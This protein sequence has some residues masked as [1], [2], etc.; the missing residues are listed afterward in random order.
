[1][2][3]D[4]YVLGVDVGGTFTDLA[5]I[6]LADGRAFYHKISSTPADPSVAVG[7]GI[8]TLLAHANVK[9]PQ[10]QY[11]G[12][13]TTVAT[14]AVI[15]GRTA[16]TGL[17]TTEGF[18]DILE[19]RRQ[20][21]PHNY[22]IRLDKPKPPVA[23]HLRREMRERV[24]LSGDPAVA[25][26]PAA[27]DPILADFKREGVEAIAICFLHSY[28]RPAHEALIAQ[29]VRERFPEAFTCASHEVLAEFREYE[30]V[31]TTAL[32][33]ALG[34][35]MSRYLI[36]LEKRA[37]AM[38]L[39][40]PKI[41]QSNGGVASA[42][43]AGNQAV[44]TLVSGPAA[45]VTG[46][47][48]LAVAAEIPDIITFDVG[49][50]STDVCLVEKGQPLI[51]RQRNFHGFPVRFPM[52]DVHSVGAGGG[53]IAWVDAG[54]F[55]H[56]GPQSAGADPGPACYDRGGGLPT[57]TD[58][59]VVLGR[60]PPD[61]LLGG[62]MPIRA[63][64][65]RRAIEERIAVPMGLGLEAAAQ[66]I[67]TILN[68]N[69]MQAI[70]VISVEKGFDPR[71]FTLVAF[72]GGG[73]LLASV[74]AREL[75][76]ATVMVP[77]HP[78]LLCAHGLLVADVRSDFSLSRLA[79][80]MQAGTPAINAG[81]ADLQRSVD[82]WFD[83]E[84]IDPAERGVERALDLRFAGQSHELTV[85]VQRAE[86]RDQDLPALIARFREE[87][88][89]VYGYAPDGALQIVTYRITARTPV[90]GPR[91]ATGIALRA[92]SSP[93]RTGSRPVHFPEAG[94]FVDCPIYDRAR[95]AAAARID[96][97]AILEQMDTT[98][99]VLPGQIARVQADGNVLLTFG[100]T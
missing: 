65:A 50:T 7:E 38:G 5:L 23:R 14:N 20:R 52:V 13:G 15:M 85:P 3:T 11:F 27:L 57:V 82:E 77:P 4:R 99:V 17:I 89:R 95:L 79:N 70:R 93:A 100:S 98:T 64:L 24:Y 47:A 61:A 74:L 40:A 60:L 83:R 58:A 59:N 72:G 1:V 16:R 96:G 10:V 84:G 45:G 92:A 35:V 18:R 81:F 2:N 44:R 49:G 91:S 62:R 88:V 28:V 22:D 51:A 33:A 42:R 94:G 53:S 37:G 66:G 97:P 6:R 73:P 21:Q 75:G 25:P 30:R 76:M 43:E 8:E 78:G 41:L 54:G 55:L 31:S 46:A 12:H 87:H 9:P 86:F 34:P 32:N 26:D 68:E 90:T 80:L 36:H 67:L 56:V 69:L 48:A 19:I 71:K 63:D 39:V 29:A